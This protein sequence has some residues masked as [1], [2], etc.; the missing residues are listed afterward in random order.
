M[1]VEKQMLI[2]ERATPITKLWHENVS[3]D[4]VDHFGFAQNINAVPIVTAEFANIAREYP[5]VF[6]GKGARIQPMALVGLR[7]N[8]NLFVTSG[9]AWDG[10]YVPAFIR[11]YPFVFSKQEEDDHFVLCLDESFEGCNTDGKGNNLFDSDGEA[12]DYLS[13]IFEFS[14]TYQRE[15]QLTDQF[16]ERLVD[17]DILSPSEISFQPKGGLK[18]KTT[19]LLSV[20]RAK[21]EKL[22]PRF[23]KQLLKSGDLERVFT[24]LHSLTAVDTFAL[25]LDKRR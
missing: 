13:K 22:P 2:Y 25:R 5:I 14:T 1:S 16:S 15:V 3:V 7:D 23:L 10:N 17:L 12:S 11:R 20:D 6:A 9:G 19:G 24:H 8:E 18:S 21:L 4:S